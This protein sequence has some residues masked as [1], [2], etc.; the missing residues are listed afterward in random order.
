MQAAPSSTSSFRTVCFAAPVMRT[1]ELIEQPSIKHRIT[2]ARR[3]VF[4]LFINTVCLLGLEMSI[5][6]RISINGYAASVRFFHLAFAAFFAI[7]LRCFAVRLSALALPPFDAPSLDNATAAG[8]FTRSGSAFGLF[9]FSPMMFSITALAN[10]TGSFGAFFGFLGLLAR[11]GM[12]RLWHNFF[13][14]P[15]P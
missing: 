7:L 1:V 13:R 14:L 6:K 15:S 5:K 12:A 10:R 11:D 4:I 3:T 9:H 8:F 2:W